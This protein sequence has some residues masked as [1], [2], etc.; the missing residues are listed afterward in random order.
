MPGSNRR[1]SDYPLLCRIFL[2]TLVFTVASTA[3]FSGLQLFYSYRLGVAAIHHR[4]DKL[5]E[6]QLEL[7]ARNV[8]ALNGEVIYLQ[9]NSILLD[10]AIV[11]LELNDST[12]ARFA[13]GR[14]PG[15]EKRKFIRQY[16]LCHT[17]KGK[18]EVI[19]R[20]KVIATTDH[21]KKYLLGE[22]PGIVGSNF[23]IVFLVCAFSLLLFHF[24]F[25]RHL[26]R[27]IAFTENMALDTLDQPL[28]LERKGHR[29]EPD[30]LD[31]VVQAINATR[32]RLYDG[33]QLRKKADRTLRES[34][35]RYRQIFNATSDAILIHDTGGRII[36]VNRALLEMYGYSRA[37]AL[38]LNIADLIRDDKTPAGKKMA[39]ILENCKEG[40]VQHLQWPVRRRNG[41]QFWIEMA[42]SQITR[43]NQAHIL[44][45]IRDIT[46]RLHL[47]AELHRSHK[48][49]A[50]GTLAGGI[51]HDFNNILSAI[52]GYTELARMRARDNPKLNASL[53]GIFQA[54]QRARD[55]IRQIL[56]FSRGQADQE[57]KSLQA[58]LIVKEA[59]KLIRSSLP[60]SIEIVQEIRSSASV[61]ANPT[62]IHQV[63]MN[64]CTNAYQ[65]MP[66]GGVLE[67]TLSESGSPNGS[68][69]CPQ[70]PPA[71]RY[72]CLT[73]RDTGVGMDPET[74]KK[75]FDPYFTRR[76]A[77]EGTGLGLAVVHGIVAS[78]KGKIQVESAPGAGST[79]RVYLPITARE[80]APP[81]EECGPGGNLH[82]QGERLLFVDDEKDLT[83]L[84]AEIISGYGY[85]IDT[86][87][88]PRAA[89]ESFT[90][91]PGRYALLITDMTMPKLSGVELACQLMQI[92]PELPV[93]ICSGNSPGMN[94]AKAAEHG[95]RCFL[96]KPVVMS[97][98]LRI[99]REILDQEQGNG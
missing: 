81:E 9:L 8:W 55:L 72:L 7:L 32:K 56:T 48:L 92:R 59:L 6:S 60:A 76:A 93:I 19:A 91:E 53:E 89:R 24:T 37:E 62:Q 57:K 39:K 34:E 99:I 83:Q 10:P 44:L 65:A 66:E 88:D 30:E 38:S 71:G 98:L 77:G 67:V 64:L 61:L 16:N 85:A 75:I 22:L 11:Y 74:Q 33:L 15:P 14:R 82:G 23:A 63:V 41:E 84:A 3:L 18:R 40:R 96:Q 29:A 52:F 2:S 5:R 69:S 73:V 42:A 87:T 51:A 97:Q 78:H 46:E 35:K 25:T 45:V 80:Q 26:S 17:L 95:F 49:E 43:N 36:D 70:G 68:Q 90:R 20:L 28:T 13:V 58:H 94:R 47:E 86:F 12:G 31:R 50:I 27:I 54:T 4:L 79:F 21:L 1:L